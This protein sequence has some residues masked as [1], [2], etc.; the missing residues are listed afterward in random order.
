MSK[1]TLMASYK[2]PIPG[3]NYSSYTVEVSVSGD[4]F[5]EVQE[6]LFDKLEKLNN[7]MLTKFEEDS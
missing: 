5:E 3:I 2:L 1:Y 6:D 4:N 7:Q